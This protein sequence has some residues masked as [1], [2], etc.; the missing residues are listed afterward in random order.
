M[1]EIVIF[2]L[3][4]ISYAI[5]TEKVLEVVESVPITQIPFVPTYV[6]GLVN[7]AGQILVQ[8]DL[9]LLLGGNIQLEQSQGVLLKIVSQGYLYALHV[10]KVQELTE[11]TEEEIHPFN[12]SIDSD[13]DELC[14]SAL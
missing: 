7:L 12:T 13:S 5:P 3:Q 14:R 11:I 2:K 1:M 9:G 6:D 8:I 10:D 4:N